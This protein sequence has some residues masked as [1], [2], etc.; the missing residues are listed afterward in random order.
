MSKLHREA[1]YVS[2]QLYLH[3]HVVE[4]GFQGTAFVQ[5][6]NDDSKSIA[7]PEVVTLDSW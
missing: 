4:C 6:S 3:Y 1:S 2:P 5:S 7:D